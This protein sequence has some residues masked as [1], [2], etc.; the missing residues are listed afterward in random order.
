MAPQR[1]ISGSATGYGSRRC[2]CI[3]GD[4]FGGWVKAATLK[5]GYCELSSLHLI[6]VFEFSVF[7]SSSSMFLC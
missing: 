2:V 5:F 4:R 3:S 7:L 6:F 1:L